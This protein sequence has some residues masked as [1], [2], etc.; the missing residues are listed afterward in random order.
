VG[1][2]FVLVQPE[3]AKNLKLANASVQADILGQFMTPTYNNPCNR[4]LMKMLKRIQ[5]SGQPCCT[6]LSRL[7]TSVYATLVPCPSCTQMMLRG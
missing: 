1:A 5:E 7:K 3:L 4:S 2:G 6:P